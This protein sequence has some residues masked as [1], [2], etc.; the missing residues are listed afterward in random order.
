MSV[1]ILQ[2]EGVISSTLCAPTSWCQSVATFFWTRDVLSRMV[3]V[4]DHPA[5]FRAI[6]LACCGDIRSVTDVTWRNDW[7][8]SRSSA[9]PSSCTLMR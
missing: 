1:Y 5:N 8:G 2:R 7:L 6:R 4:M 3:P 9:V